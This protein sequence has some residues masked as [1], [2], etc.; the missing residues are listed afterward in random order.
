M[1]ENKEKWLGVFIPDPDI[2]GELKILHTR[3]EFHDDV[4]DFKDIIDNWNPEKEGFACPYEIWEMDREKG[5]RNNNRVRIYY[6]QN[7]IDFDKCYPCLE[8]TSEG[9]QSC[10]GLYYELINRNNIVH[11]RFVK[12]DSK[13]GREFDDLKNRGKTALTLREIKCHM[14][15]RVKCHDCKHNFLILDANPCFTCPENPKNK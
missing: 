12:R 8:C 7:K 15:V 1:I 14:F 3:T 4:Q 11:H 5:R 13:M 6:S 9:R 2:K 10:N